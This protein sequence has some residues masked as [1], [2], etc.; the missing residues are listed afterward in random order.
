[1][2]KKLQA[3]KMKQ[4]ALGNEFFEFFKKLAANNNKEWFDVNRKNYELH[5]KIP[6]EK[7]VQSLLEEL[8][9]SNKELSLLKPSDCIFRINR[10]IRFS[11]DKTPYKLNRSAAI[12]N[13]GKKNMDFAGFYFEI[14]PG[15]CAMYAGL[16]MPSK[17]NVEK[18]REHIVQNKTQFLKILNEPGFVK[19]FGQLQGKGQKR[20]APQWKEH[21]TELPVLF[22]T[23]FYISHQF[24]PENAMNTDLLE[25]LLDLN[26]SAAALNDFLNKAIQ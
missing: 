6:F 20:L 25:L 5:V 10:D 21:A 7:L 14:G 19:K 1:M 18:I 24:S 17:E 16:Y 8:S 26:K 22:Q 13:G 3:Y 12:S 23:Q 15:E 11:N 4:A 9:K 2:A